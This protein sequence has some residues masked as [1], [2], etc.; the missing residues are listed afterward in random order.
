MQKCLSTLG[1]S[2][3]KFYLARSETNPVFWYTQSFHIVQE[4][5]KG[6]YDYIIAS[7][8][9]AGQGEV[10]QELAA[11]ES[12]SEDEDEEDEDEEL[13]DDEG[14]LSSFRDLNVKLRPLEP[15]ST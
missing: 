5:N 12:E 3:F 4:F 13:S 2:N 15:N 1:K 6:V 9:S 14:P 11:A 7:D 10:D 8:E